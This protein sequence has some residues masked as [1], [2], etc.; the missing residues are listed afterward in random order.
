MS[1]RTNCCKTFVLVLLALAIVA[2][3]AFAGNICSTVSGNCLQSEYCKVQK[4]TLG[5]TA[6]DVRVAKVINTRNKDG[7]PIS[8]CVGGTS[9]TFIADFLVTTS[10]TASRSNVGLYFSNIDSSQ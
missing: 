3:P 8:S 7:S 10:S 9:F 5:C 2:V 6:N 4:Q 1:C